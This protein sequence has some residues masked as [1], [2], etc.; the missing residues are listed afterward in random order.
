MSRAAM[1]APVEYCFETNCA[2]YQRRCEMVNKILA[3]LGLS[4]C[5][6][7]LAWADDDARFPRDASFK[8][9]ITTPLVIEGLTGDN[10]GNLYTT[11]RGGNPCPVWQISLASP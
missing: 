4:L 6:W 1:F 9:L 7:A 11:G 2:A 5:T 3:F 10:R 8:T